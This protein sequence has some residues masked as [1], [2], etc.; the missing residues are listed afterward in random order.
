MDINEK[1]D[2]R[3]ERDTQNTLANVHQQLTY[4]LFTNNVHQL[5]HWE[6]AK[7]GKNEMSFKSCT[8][9]NG[10]K[11]ISTTVPESFTGSFNFHS[12]ICLVIAKEKT[13]TT[14]AAA[15]SYLLV[16][17]CVHS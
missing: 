9:S 7:I 4:T 5:H 11:K 17:C 10:G 14:T 13:A 8:H 15:E 2:K 3:N 1:S 12:V 6:T 16:L